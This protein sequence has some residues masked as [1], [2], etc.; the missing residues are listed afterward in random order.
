MKIEDS[1]KAYKAMEEVS[2]QMRANNNDHQ[3]SA[4]QLSS[5]YLPVR[6]CDLVMLPYFLYLYEYEK[7]IYAL[8]PATTSKPYRTAKG[9]HV[10]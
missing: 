1:I 10:F 4:S 9:L 5:K 8:K 6:R 7:I 3:R 2:T